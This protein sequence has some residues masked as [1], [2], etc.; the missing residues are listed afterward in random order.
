[1][2]ARTVEVKGYRKHIAIDLDDVVLDLLGGVKQVIKKEYD[3]ELPEITMCDL[4]LVLKPIL[5]EPWMNWMRRRDWLW[6]T[7]P[8][9][10]GAIG[11][12]STLR[13]QGYY[14]EIVT[15]KPEWAE[16]SVWKWLGLWR[17]AVH[18]VTIVKPTDTKADRT[19]ADVLIDDK[20]ENC[21]AFAKTGRLAILFDRGH[22]RSYTPQAGIIRAVGWAEVLERV[23][24]AEE[25][26]A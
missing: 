12:I 3:I 20:V 6:S 24:L 26:E 15:S 11:A 23:R 1:M 13:R 17:P 5:G 2:A 14:L 25:P 10:N 22:N 4:N 21:E 18:R 16:A 8:A 7:F 9:V 19:E